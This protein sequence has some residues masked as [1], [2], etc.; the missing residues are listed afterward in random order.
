MSAPE[1]ADTEEIVD[2]SIASVPNDIGSVPGL[3][4]DIAFLGSTHELSADRDGRLSLLEKARSLV[5][6]L[7]T[8]RE[9]ML[10]HVGAEVRRNP[11]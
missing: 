3:L 8:P 1:T 9:T 5:A 7:E 10:K 11:Q 4:D 6:A 2:L